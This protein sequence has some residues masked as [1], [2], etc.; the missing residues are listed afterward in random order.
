M[1]A[2][3]RGIM[4]SP[5]LL[6]A[7]M[8]VCAC[9]KAVNELG[10]ASTMD[11]ALRRIEGYWNVYLA[12]FGDQAVV[13]HFDVVDRRDGVIVWRDGRQ[14]RTEEEQGGTTQGN[15]QD[16]DPFGSGSAWR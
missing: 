13:F 5:Y 8:H 14:L 7:Y 9:G 10:T 15:Q 11:K 3:A 4:H 12:F 16:A 1:A 2:T 6:R